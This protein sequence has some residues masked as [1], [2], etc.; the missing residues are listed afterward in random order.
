MPTN[1]YSLSPG[2]VA[3]ASG[4]GQVV[5]TFL[6]N[7]GEFTLHTSAGVPTTVIGHKAFAGGSIAFTMAASDF[8]H[9]R[10]RGTALVT[11]PTLI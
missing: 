6:D 2:F 9:V 11:A 7:N 1:T 4:A 10:G 5:L 8:L 3:V